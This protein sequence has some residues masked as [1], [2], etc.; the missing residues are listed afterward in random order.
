M[1]AG[2][3][4]SLANAAAAAASAFN[5]FAAPA[6]PAPAAAPP[7]PL[8]ALVAEMLGG[9]AAPAPARARAAPEPAA[10]EQRRAERRAARRAERA[11]AAEGGPAEAAEAAEEEELEEYRNYVPTAAR[12]R[13]AGLHAHPDLLVESSSLAS[14]AA[15]PLGARAELHPELLAAAR[16]EAISDAQVEA[17][18]RATQMFAGAAALPDGSR[19]GFLLGDGAGVGKGRTIAALI[20]QHWLEGGR[21]VLWLSVSTDL[22]EDAKRDLKDIGGAPILDTFC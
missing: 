13:Y 20:L 21:R 2:W 22:I 16:G 4:A 1:D 18:A 12:A 8:A 5:R 14:A 6:P 10:D 11:A 17:V 3:A 15:P 7:Q 9:G 19:P